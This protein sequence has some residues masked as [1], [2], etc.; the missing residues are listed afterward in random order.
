LSEHSPKYAKIPW[1]IIIVIMVIGAVPHGPLIAMAFL[2]FQDP[3]VV[4][5]NSSTSQKNQKN[6]QAKKICIQFI[7]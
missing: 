6:L 3:P 2:G 5:K 7:P 1:L 4:W